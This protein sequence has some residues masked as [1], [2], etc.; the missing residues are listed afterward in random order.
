MKILNWLFHGLWA[1]LVALLILDV[2]VIEYKVDNH[3]HEVEGGVIPDECKPYI[4]GN[5]KR[6]A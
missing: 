3:R 6:T 1:V 2:I 4:W 5:T